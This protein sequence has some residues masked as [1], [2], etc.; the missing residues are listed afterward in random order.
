M[1]SWTRWLLVALAISIPAAAYAVKRLSHH[2]CPPTPDC[3]CH[4]GEA[5]TT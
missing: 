2:D 3:P 5:P 4:H 1:R